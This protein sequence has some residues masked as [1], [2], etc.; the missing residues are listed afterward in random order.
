MVLADAGRLSTST[1]NAG[2]T[3]RAATSFIVRASNIGSLLTKRKSGR[4]C[5]LPR[6]TTVRAHPLSLGR[7]RRRSVLREAEPAVPKELEQ[8]G[9]HRQ[10]HGRLLVDGLLHGVDRAD[11]P[12]EVRRLGEALGVDFRRPRLALTADLLRELVGLAQDA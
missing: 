6:A 12:V 5:Q 10:H 3:S 11:E 4:R 8:L 2:E 1:N 9:V 7:V